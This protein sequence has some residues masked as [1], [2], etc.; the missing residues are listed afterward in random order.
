MTFYKDDAQLPD[1]LDYRMRG[2]TYRYFQGQPLYPFGYGLSYTSFNIS[3]PQY[4]EGK[5]SLTLKN[6]GRREGTETVQVYMR[7]V[8]DAEGPLK[9]LRAYQ[10]VTLRPGESRQVQIDFPRERFENWDAQTNT[11]RVVPGEYELM[12]G[13]SSLDQDLQRLTV[14]VP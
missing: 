7:R 11:M 13:T 14:S 6:T 9:T 5:I 3:A 1:F 12:V 4:A 10:R 8:A 2:R